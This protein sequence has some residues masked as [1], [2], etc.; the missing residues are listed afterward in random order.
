V[1]FNTS[2]QGARQVNLQPPGNPGE[3]LPYLVAMPPPQTPE[4][5]NHPV[6]LQVTQANQM[7]QQITIRS[8]DIAWSFL[9]NT[10]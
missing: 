8:L 1:K 9:Q 7:S 4:G 10:G 3:V 2:R 5:R 6:I